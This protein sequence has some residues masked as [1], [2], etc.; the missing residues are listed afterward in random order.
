VAGAADSGQT[1]DR[2]LPKS[3]VELSCE[4]QPLREFRD[5][6]VMLPS[7]DIGLDFGKT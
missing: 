2:P 7:L 1:P 3:A 5:I 6:R 4:R